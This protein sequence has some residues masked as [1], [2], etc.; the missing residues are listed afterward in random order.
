MAQD[1]VSGGALT[2]VG[3]LYSPLV[4]MIFVFNLIVGTGALAMPGAF[5]SAG[6]LLSLILVGCIGFTSYVTVS[7]ILESMACANAMLQYGRRI[8]PAQESEDSPLVTPNSSNESINDT[9]Q[10]LSGPIADD[11]FMI[12]ERVEL[13]QMVS[14]FFNKVGVV[15]FYICLIVYLYGD[16]AIYAAAVPKS[17]RDIICLYKP[18]YPN[19]SMGWNDTL[20]TDATQCFPG[21]TSISRMTAYRLCVVLFALCLG[22][23]T[24]FNVQK[25]TALQLLTTF[26]R[27]FSFGSMIVLALV[28]LSRGPKVV[29]KTADFAHVPDLFGVCVYSFMC[30]HSLPS[31]VTPIRNKSRLGVLLAGDYILVF[32]F[33]A[34]LSLTAVFA[35]AN[36]P[37]LYTLTFEP[38]HCPDP[39]NPAPSFFQYFLALFPVFTLSTNF[40]IIS[41]TL[42]NN[43]KTLF[44][45]PD[46]T[47]HFLIDRIAFP[48]LVLLPP[49]AVAVATSRV[50]FLVGIT[51]SYA[52]S[53]VQ[54]FI[55]VALVYCARKTI[56]QTFGLH[57][58]HKS[59]SPFKHIAWLIGLTLW[60]TACII[61]VT[62][63]FIIP[64]PS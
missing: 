32:S 18:P 63:K 22:P 61:F 37:E 5:Q 55:P 3:S 28:E 48:F 1:E 62:I 17:L 2:D 30:H 24:F 59:V 14:L 41:I 35:F 54:Y 39:N 26:L 57:V 51:G 47:Y 36:I 7:Y 11:Y 42:R 44:L 15:L 50:D 45:K 6:W 19:C 27:W 52:G 38:R 46:K 20:L 13:G 25:T 12:R 53:A 49:I 34:L 8:K 9:D 23:F 21:V 29:A 33:Y 10:L 16:L 64:S 43:M 60:A 4:G 31:L 58:H 56:R 40:P